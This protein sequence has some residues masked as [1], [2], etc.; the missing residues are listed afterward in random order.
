[1]ARTPEITER[2]NQRWEYGLLWI[3]AGEQSE[4]AA[5]ISSLR[6][7]NHLGEE[8]WEAI[9]IVPAQPADGTPNN[10]QVLLKRRRDA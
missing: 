5:T 2:S 4:S 10:Y 8:G 6:D 9:G 3:V 1:M 7:L